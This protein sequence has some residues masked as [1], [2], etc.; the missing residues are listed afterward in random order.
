MEW[1]A[2]IAG[3]ALAGSVM[4]TATTLQTM[5]VPPSPVYL[6]PLILGAAILGGLV[7]D[8]DLKTSK[9]GQVTGALSLIIQSLWGHRTLFHAP[10]LYYALYILSK[11]RLGMFGI[12]VLAFM[13]G[14]FSHIFL[15]MMNAKGVPLF[16]P[17]P[18]HYHIATIKT[19]GNV[20]KILTYVLYGLTAVIIIRYLVLL[21]T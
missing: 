7:P 2:H 20:E 11:G 9:A 17:L 15:D 12:P 21:I 18:G 14:A 19:G 8:I 10:V 6:H 16:Y 3:G 1:K 13:A 5:N 4:L